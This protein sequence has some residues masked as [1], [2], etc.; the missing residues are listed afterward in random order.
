M[1]LLIVYAGAEWSDA[2]VDDLSRAGLPAEAEALIACI[3]DSKVDHAASRLAEMFPRWNVTTVGCHQAAK[4]SL[5]ETAR[6]WGPDLTVVDGGTRMEPAQL[7]GR[8]LHTYLLH[9][10]QASVRVGRKSPNPPGDPP[11]L[12]VAVGGAAPSEAAVRAIAA[13]HWPPGTL[14]HIVTAVNA[15]LAQSGISG[16]LS[17][18]HHRQVLTDAMHQS[19][20][21]LQKAGLGVTTEF[22]DAVPAELIL[23]QAEHFHADCVFL[24]SRDPG[25]LART[26][27]GSVA[28]AVFSQ[29]HCSVEVVRRKS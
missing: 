27:L 18:A 6:T 14:V 23:S 5:L 20:D 16:E 8:A 29:A 28:S 3:K 7:F 9:H 26:L 21:L 10:S 19:A 13:R 24:G 12:I 11:R 22:R 25:F 15:M 1:K 4:A 2:A 17:Y